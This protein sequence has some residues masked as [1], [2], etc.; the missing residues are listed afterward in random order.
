MEQ[1]STKVGLHRLPEYL[2]D[3]A[4]A[5]G[6]AMAGEPLPPELHAAGDP[7]VVDDGAAAGGAG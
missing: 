1:P 4:F 3:A 2:N 7:L 6:E 5:C